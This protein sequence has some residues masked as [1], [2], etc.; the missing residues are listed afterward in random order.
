LLLLFLSTVLLPAQKT[1]EMEVDS[2]WWEQKINE[3]DY[4]E[5]E[6][7]YEPIDRSG[8][9]PDLSWLFSPAFTYSVLF[10]IIILLLILFYKLYLKNLL[11]NTSERKERSYHFFEE[12]DLDEHFYEMDLEHILNSALASK[13]WK[14]AIRIHYLILLKDLIDR[15]RI[16]WHRDL[17]NMQI[18]RQLASLKLENEFKKVIAVVELFWYGD[19]LADSNDLLQFKELL[20]NFERSIKGGGG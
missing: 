13:D 19:Q 7:K 1:E 20:S 18:A 6:T 11:A 5:E 9:N 4:T 3:L 16:A 15:G 12:K 14:M 17:T 2:I 8:T 10:V